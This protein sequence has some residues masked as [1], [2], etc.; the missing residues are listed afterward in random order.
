[1]RKVVL[2]KLMSLDGA[3]DDPGRYFPETRDPHGLPV[4]DD[5]LIRLETEMIRRQDRV[6]LGRNMFDEWSGYWPTS[7][8]QPFADF[9]NSVEKVVITSTP[10]KSQWANASAAIGTPLSNV[11]RD[12]VAR[13]G[14]DIGIHGSIQLAQSALKEG[15]VDEINLAVGRVLDPSGRRLFDKN[16]LDD[17]RTLE[18]IQAV[19]TP[20]G[21]LWLSY[22]LDRQG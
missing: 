8:E 10:L 6:L 16:V 3:V 13:P 4:F 9:I 17:I 20:S 5:E 14:E 2:Y 21:S 12:L 18:L 15:L 11:I 1:M 19:P 22:R 7:N